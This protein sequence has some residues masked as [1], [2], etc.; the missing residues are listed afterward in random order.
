MEYHIYRT[1]T[2]TRFR[3]VTATDG[4]PLALVEAAPS[5]GKQGQPQK[6]EKR[7]DWENSKLSLSLSPEELFAL[8]AK[9]EEIRFFKNAEPLSLYHDPQKA[10]RE[11][12]PKELI[13]APYSTADQKVK[14]KFMAY[15][16]LREKN[17]QKTGA[18]HSTILT[19]TDLYIIQR[20]TTHMAM[21]IKEWLNP[22]MPQRKITKDQQA[23][24][25]EFT[26]PESMEPEIEES[27]IPF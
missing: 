14:M 16:T 21:F 27:D 20:L 18:Q 4:K 17:G 19:R 25:D 1:K 24:T 12:N 3:L 13:L 15:L 22:Q 26:Q 6:G 2:A 5:L 11:G 8:A 10:N 7:Y 23:E 9:C